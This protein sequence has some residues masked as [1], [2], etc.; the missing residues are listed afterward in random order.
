M[1]KVLNIDNNFQAGM[2]EITK[3]LNPKDAPFQLSV[4][5][6]LWVD[7]TFP[8]SNQFVDQCK[9]NYDANVVPVD[10][11]HNAEPAR[12]KINDAIATQTHDKIKDLLPG[13]SV[14]SSTALVLTN[15]IYFK[16]TWQVPFV[17]AQT[18][19]QPFHAA[20]GKDVTVPLMKSPNDS[21]FPYAETGDAQIVSLMYKVAN[22]SQEIGAG[23]FAGLPA[24]LSMIVILPKKADGLAAIEKQADAATITKWA[25]NLQRKPVNVSLPRFTMTTQFELSKTLQAL[26][27]TD[28]FTSKSDFSGISSSAGNKLFISAVIHKAFID[29]NEEGT[30]AAGATGVVMRATAVRVQDPPVEFRAD[31]PFLFLIRENS[32]G[33][34]LFMGR[35]NNPKE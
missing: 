19:D 29:V 30:E 9:K 35:V 3:T 20:G 2:A 16:G 8:L 4:A 11:V 18:Q 22:G 13:G 34:I 12:K 15:A 1:N 7:Q 31:H 14:D 25:G 32:T 26:G 6:A 33:S 5:N 10:F 17:K 27:M 21:S 28:A 23:G 24:I